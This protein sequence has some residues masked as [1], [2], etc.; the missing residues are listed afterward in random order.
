MMKLLLLGSKKSGLGIGLLSAV[1][2]S[3]VGLVPAPLAAMSASPS[4]TAT[5]R[6]KVDGSPRAKLEEERRDAQERVAE[7]KSDLKVKLETKKDESR[8]KRCEVKEKVSKQRLTNLRDKSIYIKER[9][10]AT[11]KRVEDFAT[12]KNLVLPNQAALLADIQTKASQAAAAAGEIK[13]SAQDF[14]CQNDDAKEQATLIKSKVEA[15]KVAVKAY[16]QAAKAYFEAVR[17]AAEAAN[18]SVSPSTVPTPS[19]SPSTGGQ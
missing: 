14:S 8:I 15:Y 12:K 13:A 6:P 2:V 17:T 3:L 1:L 18:P 5:S 7:A 10:D 4:P 16:R 11:V 9:I 19:A